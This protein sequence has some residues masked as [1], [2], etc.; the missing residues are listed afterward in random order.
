MKKK[1]EELDFKLGISMIID[2]LQKND[3]AYTMSVLAP[4]SGVG[5]QYMSKSEIEEILKIN[6]YESKAHQSLL[7]SII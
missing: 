4:E 6:T 5:G 1:A 3:M 7:T 2:F